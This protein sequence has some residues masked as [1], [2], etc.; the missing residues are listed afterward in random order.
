MNGVSMIAQRRCRLQ[1]PLGALL[2]LVTLISVA[3]AFWASREHAYRALLAEVTPLVDRDGEHILVEKA[4]RGQ[5]SSR[6]IDSVRSFER[7]DVVVGASFDTSD[8]EE[9]AA[10]LALATLKELRI[11]EPGPEVVPVSLTTLKELGVIKHGV[12]VIEIGP[13]VVSGE[14]RPLGA[15]DPL[16]RQIARTL[17]SLEKLD[18]VA[19]SVSGEGLRHLT[20]LR[21]LRSLNLSRTR[22]SDEELAHVP[23]M[24]AL[25][26]LVLDSTGPNRMVR[27]NP[28]ELAKVRATSYGRE[29]TSRRE[30]TDE[31]LRRLA[32]AS[33]LRSLHLREAKVIGLAFKDLASLTRLEEVDLYLTDFNDD[34]AHC[35]AALPSI[36][37]LDLSMT[38]ITSAALADISTIR[39]LS[40]LSLWA[41]A[42]DDASLRYLAK[43]PCLSRLNLGYT[44]ISDAGLGALGDCRSL[45]EVGIGHCPISDAGLMHLAALPSLEMVDLSEAGSVT[46]A[47]VARLQALRPGLKVNSGKFDGTRLNSPN[48]VEATPVNLPLATGQ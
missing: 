12:R 18:L 44:R 33:R 26:E 22:I 23:T 11:T 13:Y 32:G 21:S 47:G 9:V 30:I 5:E 15:I 38:K 36:R 43:L 16:L 45:K 28:A 27:L 19:T 1:Y 29:L 48:D 34:G 6:R 37:S 46:A 20:A 42:V 41:T 35:L 7:D 14:E 10:V 8:K 40:T 39:Q 31:G 2:A 17:P 25:E 24:R 3:L 4:G